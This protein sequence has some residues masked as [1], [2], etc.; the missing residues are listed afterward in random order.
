MDASSNPTRTHHPPFPTHT[1]HPHVHPR[2]FYTS[3][4]GCRWGDKCKFRHPEG[5]EGAPGSLHQAAV[6]NS[7]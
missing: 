6:R 3:G 5:E 4:G 2:R 1:Y 7:S